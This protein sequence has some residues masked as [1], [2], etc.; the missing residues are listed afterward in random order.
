MQPFAAAVQSANQT[1]IQPAG[2][3]ATGTKL[4]PIEEDDSNLIAESQSRVPKAAYG[5][6]KRSAL[7]SLYSAKTVQQMQ[8]GHT[9]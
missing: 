7:S 2:R 1:S 4:Q 3:T 8:F 5:S 6:R 9:I